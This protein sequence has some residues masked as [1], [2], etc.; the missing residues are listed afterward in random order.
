ME[1]LKDRKIV[2][3]MATLVTIVCCVAVGAFYFAGIKTNLE[4]RI[5]TQ[6][7]GLKH[8]MSELN[9]LKMSQQK[10]NDKII[11]KLEKMNEKIDEQNKKLNENTQYMVFL[12]AKGG[13]S[14]DE[15][16]LGSK[17]Y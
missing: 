12:S 14:F 17:S 15:S 2:L 10:Y 5:S 9:S 16:P 3:Q 8:V 11:I 13:M 4:Y 6:E 7:T 1:T